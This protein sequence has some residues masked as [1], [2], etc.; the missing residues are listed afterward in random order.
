M[1][2]H[3]TPSKDTWPSRPPSPTGLTRRSSMNPQTPSPHFL[4]NI[5]GTLISTHNRHHTHHHHRSSSKHMDTPI[6]I[7][8]SIRIRRCH[9][10][11]N[12]SYTILPNPNRH[13]MLH[14]KA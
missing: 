12:S 14:P 5:H 10:T 11:H 7:N 4:A 9:S 8:T 2:T 1:I 13:S 6:R 3:R